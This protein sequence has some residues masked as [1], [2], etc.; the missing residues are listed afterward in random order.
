MAR[1]GGLIGLMYNGKFWI[2]LGYIQLKFHVWMVDV[3]EY[4]PVGIRAFASFIRSSQDYLLL[5]SGPVDM[6]SEEKVWRVVRLSPEMSVTPF[7]AFLQAVHSLSQLHLVPGG[8]PR[9]VAGEDSVCVSLG[10][11]LSML[12]REFSLT[13]QFGGEHCIFK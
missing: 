2:Q 3:V 11:S 9:L 4:S 10:K 12:E 8:S 6:P 13:G 7:C 5:I 1:C